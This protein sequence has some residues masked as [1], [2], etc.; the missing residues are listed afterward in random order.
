MSFF[1]PS[2]AK[3]TVTARCDGA[4]ALQHVLALEVRLLRLDAQSEQEV[5]VAT[6]PSRRHADVVGAYAQREGLRPCGIDRRW[7]CVRAL[8]HV[9]W[10]DAGHAYVQFAHAGLGAHLHVD[11][12]RGTNDVG[13][14][15]ASISVG[16]DRRDRRPAV[17]DELATAQ[18]APV[19]NERHPRQLQVSDAG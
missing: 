8:W 18:L 19:D 2:P 11:G 5:R 14:G 17:A 1:T 15:I 13:L 9:P 12:A 6:F 7:R 10:I 3:A 16:A 4:R